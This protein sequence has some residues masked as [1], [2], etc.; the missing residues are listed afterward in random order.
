MHQNFFPSFNDD[1]SPA[2]RFL[3]KFTQNFFVHIVPFPN[4]VDNSVKTEPERNRNC[5]GYFGIKT[6]TNKAKILKIT[7]K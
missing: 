3:L 2:N 1:F 4:L 6:K 7:I 5:D